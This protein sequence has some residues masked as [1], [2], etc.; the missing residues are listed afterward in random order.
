MNINPDF[1]K[2]FESS[3][4]LCLVLDP[5]LKIV[6]VS[7]AYLSATM[8]KRDDI[9][10]KGIFE[11]FPDNPDDREATGT[12]NLRAS[13]QRVLAR[14]I[15]DTMAIQKYDIRRP[16]NE[17]GKF[18]VH[19]WSPI[20]CPVLNE[21]DEL[22]YI[23]HRVEEVTEFIKI[24]D[25][26]EKNNNQCELIEIE[27]FERNKALKESEEA[28]KKAN[29][30]LES[31]SY[32]VSHDLRAPL[33][34]IDGFSKILQEKY[35][36]NMSEDARHYLDMIRESA[37][38]MGHLIDDLL[39]FSRLG[40]QEVSNDKISMYELTQ[41][42]IY[43]VKQNG[44]KRDI[45]IT[46]EPLPDTN[47]DWNLLKQAMINLI[48]NACKYTRKVENPMIIIGAKAGS[49]PIVYYVKDNG[50]GFNMDYAKKLFGVFQRLHS[51][52]EY[53][54]RGVGLAIV[55]RIITKHGGSVWAE[56]KE[57]EGATFYFTLGEEYNGN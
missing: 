55:K 46:I 39:A 43:F 14:K 23:V 53:E 20:N 56:S 48:S 47:G 24:K 6:A 37:V 5:F 30:E 29:E 15:P 1:K 34:A 45:D 4:A 31:F 57:G 38:D 13:L 40:R 7:D 9:L 52:E 35:Q 22:V 17:G 50:V 42:A 12:K 21:N 3:P 32:S 36:D 49:Y 33:R 41:S 11:V 10:G 51:V 28:L 2:I 19:Y 8:T 27:I 16:S 25:N 18:E 26:K 44:E 54:G